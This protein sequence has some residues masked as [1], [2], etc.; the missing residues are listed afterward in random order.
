MAMT[1]SRIQEIAFERSLSTAGKYHQFLT[2]TNSGAA[3]A[4]LA[5]LASAKSSIAVGWAF[6]PMSFFALGILLTAFRLRGASRLARRHLRFV[7]KRMESDEPPGV[8][9]ATYKRDADKYI[10]QADQLET[11]QLAVLFGGLIT[12]LG[13]LFLSLMTWAG[14]D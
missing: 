14:T 1:D 11:L 3:A 12:G 8:E 7:E 5:F 10:V 2:L 6:I 13:L 9:A 4:V